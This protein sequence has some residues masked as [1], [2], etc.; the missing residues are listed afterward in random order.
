[1]TGYQTK[2][3]TN[4][5]APAGFEAG[6]AANMSRLRSFAL[7]LS[8]NPAQADDL[9]QDT[10]VKALAHRHTFAVDTNQRAWL[11]KI[12]KNTF[13]SDIRR[14]NREVSLEGVAELSTGNKLSA[15]EATVRL[16][17]L[18]KE[19]KSLPP[20]YYQS[21]MLV[22]ALGMSYAETAAHCGCAVGTIKSRVNRARVSLRLH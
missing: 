2:T 9:V 11:F 21:L 6:L 19:M 14:R 15:Q 7:R 13:L 16:N 20:E 5:D 10:L 18:D 8:A 12:L 22:G 4:A 3:P 1:M 17:E